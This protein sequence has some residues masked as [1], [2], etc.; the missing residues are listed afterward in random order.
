MN[1]GSNV[2]W[3]LKYTRQRETLFQA[4]YSCY[5]VVI[6]ALHKSI[7]QGMYSSTATLSSSLTSL[8]R[9]LSTPRRQLA[10]FAYHVS[11]VDVAIFLRLT[12]SWPALSAR[13]TRPLVCVGARFEFSGGI[14]TLIQNVRTKFLY[15]GRCPNLYRIVRQLSRL[16]LGFCCFIDPIVTWE[17]SSSY[18]PEHLSFCW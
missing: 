10:R 15:Y 13:N 3:C 2:S 8:R 4:Q 12:R 16:M 9:E 18:T 17:Q 6:E 14:P 7:T 5:P 11:R 1:L